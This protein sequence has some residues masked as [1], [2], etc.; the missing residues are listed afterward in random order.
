MSDR[1]RYRA[2]I[3]EETEK[4]MHLAENPDGTGKSIW[5][6]KSLLMS[7]SKS[8]PSGGLRE[9]HFEVEEWKEKDIP[10]KFK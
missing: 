9:Y 3:R 6:P 10:F 7:G 2:F 5:L 4:A 1:A 8:A